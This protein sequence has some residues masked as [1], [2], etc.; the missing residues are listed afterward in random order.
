VV[1]TDAPSYPFGVDSC[2][3]C[4]GIRGEQGSVALEERNCGRILTDF[5]A[6]LARGGILGS[7][8]AS[9]LINEYAGRHVRGNRP[10]GVE[11]D[12]ESDQAER[13]RVVF[14]G[15]FSIH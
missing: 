8:S 9:K 11:L 2:P 15:N 6:P 10:T 1:G 12:V 7:R 5:C 4:A 13:Q 14:A 3:T